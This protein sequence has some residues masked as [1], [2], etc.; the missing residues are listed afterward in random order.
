MLALDLSRSV[1]GQRLAHLKQAGRAVLEAL[2]PGDR[3]AL[4]TFSQDITLNQALTNDPALIRSALNRLEGRGDTAGVDGLYASIL[5]AANIIV[6]HF[7]QPPEFLRARLQTVRAI[8]RLELTPEI[9]ET[10]LNDSATEITSL[11]EMLG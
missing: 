3:V 1:A 5:V 10:L 7:G 8:S 11:R 9:C 2:G 6:I 4:L